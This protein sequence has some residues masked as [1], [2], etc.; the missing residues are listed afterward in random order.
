MRTWVQYWNTGL[1][2]EEELPTERS[3]THLPCQDCS[4]PHHHLL[5]LRVWSHG[6]SGN[7]GLHPEPAW[8]P[9]SGHPVPLPAV[10]GD[11]PWAGPPAA[12]GLPGGQAVSPSQQDLRGRGALK[13]VSC[14]P[15]VQCLRGEKRG[16]ES[17]VE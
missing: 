16:G 10:P 4:L 2:E 13:S 9:P 17:E 15:A 1:E 3:R 12:G 6:P 5:I 11:R 7:G 14:P 8:G